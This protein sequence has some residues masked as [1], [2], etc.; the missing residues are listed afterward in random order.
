M[1][2]AVCGVLGHADVMTSQA[3]RDVSFARL[4][5]HLVE[6]P[7]GLGVLHEHRHVNQSGTAMCSPRR[8]ANDSPENE[9]E[10]PE[11]ASDLVKLLC[12]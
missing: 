4:V 8:T 7:Q 2:V 11:G 3:D 12:A 5:V 6:L 9:E 1:R 10:A